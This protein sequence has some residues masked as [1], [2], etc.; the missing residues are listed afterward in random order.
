MRKKYIQ[1]IWRAIK[2]WFTKYLNIYTIFLNN[3]KKTQLLKLT[4]VS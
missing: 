1:K 4:M 3:E 2:I